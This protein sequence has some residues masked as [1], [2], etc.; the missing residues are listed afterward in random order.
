MLTPGAEA[1]IR[2]SRTGHWTAASPTHLSSE[3]VLLYALQAVDWRLERLEISF[4]RLVRLWTW[5]MRI[6]RRAGHLLLRTPAAGLCHRLMGHLAADEKYRSWFVQHRA[7]DPYAGTRI[8]A[9]DV[10]SG[11]RLISVIMPV[12]RPNLD[13]LRIA[14]NSVQTQTYRDWQLLIV[15][16]GEQDGD[17]L[18]QLNRIASEDARILC[19]AHERGGISSTLNRGLTA[20]S[21]DYTAFI[22]QDDILEPTALSH[23][24]AAI[25]QDEPDILYTDEDYVDEHGAAHLPLFKPAWSPALLLSCMYFG[26]LVVVNTQRAKGIG[27][28]RS[29]YDGAQDY[30]FVLRLTDED[31]SVVHIPRVLY[32]WRRH[33]DSTAANPA[34]KSYSHGAGLKALEDTLSRRQLSAAV[35]DGP[36]S[37]SYRL[38]HSFSAQDSAAVIVPTRNAKLLTRLL[39]SMDA[40]KGSLRQEVYVILH[41]QGTSEDERIAAAARKFGAKVIEF[42]GPFNFSLMNNLAAVRISNPYLVLINDDVVV[43]GDRWLEDLCSPF[44]RSEVGVV[45]ARLQYPDGTIEH[46]GVVTGIGEGVG[47]SGRFQKGSPFWPWLELTRNVS[48]VTGACLAIRRTVF[49]QIGGFD[50]RFFNN[51]NDVDLCL[52]AQSAG[53]EVVLSAGSSLCHD[54]A[55]TRG[56]GTAFRERIDFWTQ[57]GTVLTEV[58]YFYSPNLSRRLETIDLSTLSLQ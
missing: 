56:A 12:Y 13:W 53:F 44:M 57:W 14:V 36:A 41:C 9:E 38:S 1:G 22:D 28:F 24:A 52:R 34:A 33:P 43:S 7:T 5:A 46:C 4:L 55:K 6:Y 21:G 15:L 45:G 30:D 10:P 54:G 25:A 23:V 37:N 19:L 3:S 27:G 58:D 42:R 47:H 49:E 11:G 48:A 31:V 20:C 32:H 35:C 51:Y 26:H 17:V 50:T 40:G 2:R 29:A 39:N 18:A 8:T 16:D